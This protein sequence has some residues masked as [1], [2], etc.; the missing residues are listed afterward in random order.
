MKSN[1]AGIE[2]VDHEVVEVP[3]TVAALT[4]LFRGASV[5]ST[6]SAPS[7]STAARW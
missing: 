3:H 5:V 4:E 1:V 2:T 7:P 6:P